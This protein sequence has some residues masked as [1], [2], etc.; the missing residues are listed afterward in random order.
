MA[1]LVVI[2]ILSVLVI[3]HELGHFLMAKRAG[4]GV[5]EFGI[6]LPV[7]LPRIWTK[8][9][10]ETNYSIYP[11]FLGGFVRLVGEDPKDKKKDQKNSFYIKSI[12]Q[13][14]LVVVAGVVAN[15]ALAVVI[16]YIV[17]A[18]LGYKVSLPLLMDHKFKFVNQTKQVLIADVSVDSPA[19]SAGIQVGDSIVSAKGQEISSIEKLQEVIRS[20]ENQPIPLVL[21][22]PVNNQTREVVAT[23][24]YSEKQQAP[25]L[26]VGLG[27][28][29][30]LNYQTLLQKVFS[31]FIH[32][33]NTLDYSVRV[34]AEIIGYSI[35]TRDITPVSEGVAGPVG[36][37]AITSQAVSL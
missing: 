35:K 36:I 29:V 19:V 34:F 18:A 8:K 25:V 32:S 20:S 28:L 37:A 3:L 4:I 13:R 2:L 17:V 24:K 9:I 5:E 26:G 21:E 1:I 22:N 33:Y 11:L 15:F 14:M 31:G 23:P 27:E 30:V 10:G 16:F 7:L 12:R 6:G